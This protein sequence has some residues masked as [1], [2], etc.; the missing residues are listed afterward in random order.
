M[1]LKNLLKIIWKN[2]MKTINCK[3]CEVEFVPSHHNTKLC[4]ICVNKKFCIKCNC[5]T[6]LSFG[7]GKIVCLNCAVKDTHLIYNETNKNE[8]IECRECGYRGKEIA[9]H[10]I[11]AHNINPSYYGLTKSQIS[12]SRME[13]EKNPAYNH[14]G[15]YSPFSEKFIKR[16]HNRKETFQKAHESKINNDSYNTKLYFYIKKTNGNVEEAKKLLVERQRTFSLEICI[17]KYGDE[18]GY[19][20]WLERQEKWQETLNKKSPEEKFNLIR[21][22]VSG[23]WSKYKKKSNSAY[24]YLLYFEDIKIMKFGISLDVERRINNLNRYFD[25]RNG[26]ILTYKKD[27]SENVFC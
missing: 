20:I 24:V 9:N 3:R 5:E 11:K 22:R 13:G 19:M 23:L 12:R 1:K 26:I 16:D 27:T 7:R 25:S 18:L 17:E 2:I 14:G 10:I 8:W 4:S 21:Q 15:L 6:N